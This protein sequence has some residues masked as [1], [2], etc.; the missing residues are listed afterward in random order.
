MELKI[1][2]DIHGAYQDLAG[3]LAP[4]DTLIMLG[5][6]VNLIDFATL[7]GILSELFTSEEI[8]QV[9]CWINGKQKAKARD[10]IMRFTHAGGDRYEEATDLIK[11]AY[12]EMGHQV[13]CKTY[14]LYGNTDYPNLMQEALSSKDNFTL[15]DGKTIELNGL[16][17]GFVSG[18]PPTPWTFSLPGVVK[19]KEYQTKLASLGPVD[20]LCAHVPPSLPDLSYD[21]VS[22]RDEV[23]SHALLAY[24]K[25]YQPKWVF[26]GHVHNPLKQQ[27]S[28]NGSQLVNVGYFRHQ[29]QIYSLKCSDD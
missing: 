14:L 10:F 9:L 28:F 7:E 2:S 20:I 25:E 17:I 23:G 18:S 11:K 27:L 24:I 16:K 22:R 1:V 29:K 19:E 12:A 26:F 21:T 8:S 13:K 3:Q 15:M 6:Y 5:D 4:D